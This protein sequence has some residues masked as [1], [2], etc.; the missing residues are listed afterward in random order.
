[1]GISQRLKETHN[2][3][4]GKH[5]NTESEENLEQ[6]R[7]QEGKAVYSQDIFNEKIISVPTKQQ[8]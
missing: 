8:E 5:Q 7:N 4:C 6:R 1:M 3:D 2:A